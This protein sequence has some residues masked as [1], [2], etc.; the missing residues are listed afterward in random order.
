MIRC[1]TL[2]WQENKGHNIFFHIS[3]VV[4]Q[5]ASTCPFWM[6]ILYPLEADRE[7]GVLPLHHVTLVQAIRL[8]PRCFAFLPACLTCLLFIFP[9]SLLKGLSFI[10]DCLMF[11][12]WCSS[13]LLLGCPFFLYMFPSEWAVQK[14]I[15]E[16][17]SLQKSLS[18]RHKIK[19]SKGSN[20]MSLSFLGEQVWP[21]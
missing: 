1:E 2:Q 21:R 10:L 12:P 18:R 7:C 4:L 17:Q 20:G 16:L 15:W 9:P 6:W 5:L 8:V 13:P 14:G 19:C 3:Q 11:L